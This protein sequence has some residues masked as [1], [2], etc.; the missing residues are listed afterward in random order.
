MLWYKVN[1]FS[2]EYSIIQSKAKPNFKILH[3]CILETNQNP[4]SKT[5]TICFLLSTNSGFK[6]VDYY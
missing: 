6:P 2:K 1:K 5:W 4:A 3:Y